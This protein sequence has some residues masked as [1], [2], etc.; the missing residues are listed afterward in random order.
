MRQITVLIADDQDMLR[1]LMRRQLGYTND[2]AVVAEAS[3]GVKAVR[4]CKQ[5]RPNVALLDI[6]MPDGNGITACQAIVTCC[7]ATHVVM[8]TSHN[9]V[10]YL[11]QAWE[12]GASAFVT[13]RMDY[14]ILIDTIRGVLMDKKMFSSEQLAGIEQWQRAVGTPLARLTERERM[15]LQQLAHGLTNPEIADELHITRK[16][17]ETH[18]TNILSKLEQPNRRAAVA[19]ARVTGAL[20]YLNIRESP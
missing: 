13:L 11:A 20:H 3:S 6:E 8:L 18:V 9:E 5:V 17:V 19:W 16:T 14:N 2:I 15:V 4:L 10:V 12:A 1:Q 7:P